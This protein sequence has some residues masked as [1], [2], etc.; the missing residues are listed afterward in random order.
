[1]ELV[2]DI[3]TDGPA[4]LRSIVE[5]IVRDSIGSWY[6]RIVTG[7]SYFERIQNLRSADEPTSQRTGTV[8]NYS[9]VEYP[10]FLLEEGFFSSSGATQ[11]EANI[12]QVSSD[13]DVS[14]AP[15]IINYLRNE[16]DSETTIGAVID[17]REDAE[18]A[19]SLNFSTE[20]VPLEVADI[21]EPIGFQ[22]F[23]GN[24]AITGSFVRGSQTEG[25]AAIEIADPQFV[26]IGGGSRVGTFV[27][28]AIRNAGEIRITLRFNA[29]ENGNI[30]IADSQTNLDEAFGGALQTEIDATVAAFRE[31][32]EQELSA[33]LAGDL[34][35]V[36]EQL[37]AIT[38]VEGSASSLL[39][40]AQA[41]QELAGSVVNRANER[42]SEIRNQVESQATDA[43]NE[44]A[45]SVR[46]R[47]QEEAESI[48]DRLP[49]PGF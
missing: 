33:Y 49:L 1:M 25:S 31:R 41:R 20:D 37:D 15:T 5:P 23:S 35:Q 38:G 26:S 10:L 46:E 4:F 34:S 3:E 48:R 17:L 28:S 32:V 43:A 16:K 13:Q 14:N 30:S 36:S 2:P 6:D 12:Q 9:T 21:L 29:D 7:Y 39:A 24:A 47:A 42:V 18:V 11:T 27:E 45:D 44:A 22:S 8:I 40:D 19:L